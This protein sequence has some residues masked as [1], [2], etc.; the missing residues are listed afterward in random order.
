MSNL[1]KTVP[2]EP[3]LQT[4]CEPGTYWRCIKPFEHCDAE[5][6]LMVYDVLYFEGI[7][8]TI[9]ILDH[10]RHGGKRT[11]KLLYTDFLE[12]FE[13]A[14]DG[15]TVRARELAALQTAINA[16]QAR[17][18][19][20]D[21]VE[22][23]TELMLEL[24]RQAQ[25]QSIPN[26]LNALPSSEAVPVA[27][28]LAHPNLN[29]FNASAKRLELLAEIRSN[30]ITA[31]VDELQNLISK[32]SPYYSEKS[33]QALARTKAV[34]EYAKSLQSGLQSLNLYTL[35]D[36]EV[37]IIRQGRSAPPSTPLHVFQAKLYAEEEHIV[38]HD[39][40]PSYD[41]YN[42]IDQFKNDLA[43][44]PAFLEQ[45]AP[46]ERA[47]VAIQTTRDNKTYQNKWEDIV[48]NNLN[49]LVFLLI[50]N[51]ENV[52][53]VTSSIETHQRSERLFPKTL[54]LDKPF[55]GI[56]GSKITI[57]DVRFVPS[58]ERVNLEK[59]HYFRLL[60]LMCG[61]D[62]HK[63]L[64][65]NFYPQEQAF[66]FLN[67]EF[68]AQYMRFVADDEDKQLAQ[69]KPKFQDWLK[70]HRDILAG[71][72]VLFEREA[73]NYR[74]VPGMV[75]YA[76]DR[77]FGHRNE[78]V[79]EPVEK[80]P[81]TVFEFKDKQL[82]GSIQG[83]GRFWRTDA[84]KTQNYAVYADKLED[85][86]HLVLDQIS[87]D[88]IKHFLHN[89]HARS[90]N[91]DQ[92]RLLKHALPTVLKLE[93]QRF[94]LARAIHTAPNHP[95][96]GWLLRRHPDGKISPGNKALCANVLNWLENP[97]FITDLETWCSKFNLTPVCL[98]VNVGKLELLVETPTEDRERRINY[99]A[100]LTCFEI[101]KGTDFSSLTSFKKSFV[102]LTHTKRSCF[103]LQ[104][105]SSKEHFHVEA[106]K[107]TPDQLNDQLEC[108]QSA[109]AAFETFKT[110]T[111]AI[112]F[113][114]IANQV[115]GAMNQKSSGYILNQQ[116]C[117]PIGLKIHQPSSYKAS[118]NLELLVVTVNAEHQLLQIANET[119]RKNFQSQYIN[120]Y[121]DRDKARAS[122]EGLPNLRLGTLRVSNPERTEHIIVGRPLLLHDQSWKINL[123]RWLKDSITHLSPAA[124]QLLEERG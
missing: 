86:H 103:T 96:V 20:V 77:S 80:F 17:I 48:K 25:A 102:W 116:L 106:E 95:L 104:D 67:P 18:D 3:N 121:W 46:A 9:E 109:W 44:T 94:T 42:D 100:W 71:S 70:T 88:D 110:G 105:W 82:I 49:K 29:G 118:T 73:L 12:H 55:R 6:V 35:E 63:R 69:G 21:T 90:S 93:Q 39:V 28:L 68:Q 22:T 122:L 4:S 60:I 78:F 26:D 87:S 89:R 114:Q 10:P 66:N 51:G 83:K 79:A 52:H 19:E 64:F 7:E 23:Q 113:E 32:L 8:H 85:Q 30:W 56:D 5:T 54:E 108:L 24:E 38:F 72:T 111:A 57:D 58:T 15:E 59:L 47:V 75:K 117:I 123:N 120:L 101:P 31:R 40:S 2:L 119:Q 13:F 112:S 65:G 53:L 92:I 97:N 91:L 74:S 37:Q 50:R 36:V 81:V 84:S 61:L 14:F 99:W 124:T 34:R 45:L 115:F 107:F 1:E 62:H 76:S 27:T 16:A 33:K 11:F 98:R 41:H 43:T